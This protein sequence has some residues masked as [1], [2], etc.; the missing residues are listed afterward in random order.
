[1]RRQL[2]FLPSS[3]AI[4]QCLSD[5]LL[6]AEVAGRQTHFAAL[7]RIEVSVL[8]RAH[9]LRAFD[10][11]GMVTPSLCRQR[12]Q[13]AIDTGLPA[14]LIDV[15]RNKCR[16]TGPLRAAR[17]TAQRRGLSHAAPVSA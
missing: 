2:C 9:R 13:D 12:S 4:A 15:P 16:S 7:W 8:R 11:I 14:L 10:L 3:R 5:G 1:M 17:L 6:L